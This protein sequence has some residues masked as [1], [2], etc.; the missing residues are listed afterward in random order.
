MVAQVD[1]SREN[2]RTYKILPMKAKGLGYSENVLK[3]YNLDLE[4]LTKRLKNME[5]GD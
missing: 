5:K 1:G 4:S 3:K 2:R